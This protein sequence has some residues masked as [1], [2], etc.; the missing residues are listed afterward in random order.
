M[1]S[2]IVPIYN[3]EKYLDKCV[4]SIVGQTYADLEIILINDGS[5]DTSS[6]RLKIWEKRDSRIKVITQDNCGVSIARKKGIASAKGS[7][8]TFVDADDYLDC[9]MYQDLI[10]TADTFD[11]DIVECG[12]ITVT[13]ENEII[14]KNNSSCTYAIKADKCIE[15]FLKNL[16][17]SV[18]LW[19]KIYRKSLFDNLELPGLNYSEDYLW[20]L[21]LHGKCNSK[22]TIDKAYYYYLKN[23]QGACGQYANNR[24][25]D[26]LVAGE[27]AYEYLGEKYSKLQKYAIKY[28]MDNCKVLYC[29]MKA[30]SSNKKKECK[31][32]LMIFDKY[33]KIKEVKDISS[34]YN[35]LLYVL[36]RRSPSLFYRI[37]ALKAY[38]RGL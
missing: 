11:C 13:Q 29:E 9:K 24:K 21:F 4:Q 33:Y 23:T 16:N 12:F 30:S 7:Y 10:E 28:I 36:F 27:R 32:I 37:K 22:A 35:R 34:L 19:N 2:V 31:Y 8:V 15:Q 17:C 25:M 38:K 20:N 1:L 3:A 5:T 26:I 6:E 18:Y 14:S